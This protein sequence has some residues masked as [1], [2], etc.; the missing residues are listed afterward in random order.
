MKKKSKKK[1]KSKLKVI[2]LLGVSFYFLYTICV[3]QQ[4]LINN[5]KSQI[6]SLKTKITEEHD[7]N[8]QLKSEQKNV[9]SDEF[10][11]NIAR[12][13]LGMLKKGERVFIDTN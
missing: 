10:I 6:D 7:L 3:Y 13:K 9:K 11:E 8:D 1:K 5:K 2:I 4:S 12:K